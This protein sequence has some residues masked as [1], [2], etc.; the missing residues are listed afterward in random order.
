MESVSITGDGSRIA[1]GSEDN[2]V[3]VWDA[4]RGQ[5]V[6]ELKGQLRRFGV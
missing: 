5:A 4:K 3:R 6:L 2:T 1:S